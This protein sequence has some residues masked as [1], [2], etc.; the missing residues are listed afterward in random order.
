MPFQFNSPLF[1]AAVGTVLFAVSGT[2]LACSSCGC[3]L[4]SDWATQGYAGDGGLRIDLRHDYFNQNQ[5]R[6]GSGTVDRSAITLPSDDEIQQKTIN[7]N[8]TLTLDWGV[9]RTLGLQ[10]QLPWIHRYHSTIAPGDTDVSVSR[11]S[12]IGDARIVARYSGF[13]EDGNVGVQLGLKLPTG[14]TGVN[15]KTG[16]Q[17]GEP[18]DAG[19]QPGTGTTDLIVGV[20]SFG[21]LSAKTQWFAQALLQQ[22]LN[23]HN[24]FKPGTGLNLNGGLRYAIS[25]TLRAQVQVNWRHEGRESGANADVD[26]SGSTLVYLSPGLTAQVSKDVQAYGFV[27]V[28]VFQRVNGLQIEPRYT[29]SLGLTW[30][31]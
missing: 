21:E 5:L 20:Y 25:D 15:F 8:T 16:P 3:T 27:Q 14:R 13:N 29:V 2:A 12:S 17:A 23:R 24:E 7:R 28:P 4:S 18:L 9:S 22:P 6:S 30:K 19:L 11:S 31:K 26:N 10:L 1:A